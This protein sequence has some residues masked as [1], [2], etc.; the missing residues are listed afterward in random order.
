MLN[1]KVLARG[2]LLVFALL[3]LLAA[4][5]ALAPADA[6]LPS[7]SPSPVS[8]AAQVGLQPVSP[9]PSPRA[10]TLPAA[11]ATP[12]YN[13]GAKLAAYHLAPPRLPGTNIVISEFRTRG[14]SSNGYASD[15]FIELFNPTTSNVDLTGW[16]LK[17]SGSCNSTE[18]DVLLDW[19]SHNIIEP[20]HHLLIGGL[21]Y[22][23][24][25][26]PDIAG[27]D[28]GA[29]DDGG[30]AL[31]DDTLPTATIIDSVGMCDTTAYFEFTPLP[32]LTANLNQSYDR[33]AEPTGE[34]TDSNVNADDFF[35]R[36][37]SD[38]QNS[39]SSVTTCGNPTP[40]PSPTLSPTPTLTSTPTSTA[41]ATLT[42]TN[43]P[44][45]IPLPPRVIINEVGWGGTTNSED[46][47][48]IEL[49][50][51]GTS[52]VVLSPDWS[53]E[54]ANTGW[55]LKLK[56]TIPAG[57]Y[58]ILARATTSQL[59]ETPGGCVVFDDVDY[60]QIFT[61][62]F[63]AS[64][65]LLN[66]KQETS[67]GTVVKDSAGQHNTAW[68]AGA[69]GPPP[70][71][72]ERTGPPILFGIPF[73]SRLAWF[74]FGGTAFAT[75]CDGRDVLGT[76][77]RA[78]WATTVLAT[79][80]PSSGRQPTARPPTPFP[81]LVINEFLPHAGTDWNQDGQVN[82]RDEFIEVQNNGPIDVD[83]AGWRLDDVANAGSPAFT[84]PSLKLQPGQRAV[85]YGANTNILLDDSGDTVRLINKNNIIVDAR[86]YGVVERADVSVCRIP[87]G[88]YWQ[89]ACFP[90][91][92]N[93][94]AITGAA[95]A[96]APGPVALS[97]PPPCLLADTVPEAFA[98]AECNGFG[99]DVYDSTYWDEPAPAVPFGIADSQ[100][101]WKTLIQ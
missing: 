74:T 92:G 33:N 18:D 3:A 2:F 88:Y 40:S 100:H 72:M 83:L 9:I 35:L 75:D 15:E 70:R 57:G 30:I 50:N 36:S 68:W 54:A 62:K 32:P 38:P 14:P 65:E 24:I 64:G 27:I 90:T 80:T 31:L 77:K 16:S 39:S 4:P 91:P 8:S 60:D 10:Q 86:S 20:G 59:T 87:D 84:L 46:D 44:T 25:V 34:C 71:S 48:W 66:L 19:G 13:G 76:P 12:A 29:A 17:R 21:N 53:I 56:G 81:H 97:P 26:T 98:L 101:K 82:V 45:P 49:Y 67:F 28:I 51:P 52:P 99:G 55:T 22:S 61:K 73:N 47:Q 96:P 41:T 7:A 93:G 79:A 11:G 23:G 69:K 1:A 95:P 5:M 85:F 58:F 6:S 63:S 37:P 94:N 42:P 89:Q 78:N 43:S